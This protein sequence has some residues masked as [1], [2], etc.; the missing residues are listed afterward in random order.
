MDEELYATDITA[1]V[2]GLIMNETTRPGLIF[3]RIAACMAEIEAVG[4]DHR[5]PQQG[6]QFRSIDDFY[7]HCHPVLAKHRVFIS[8]TILD[9]KREE[10]TT[11]SGS[12]MMTTLTHVRYRVWTEDGSY[13]EADAIGEGADS[14]DKSANKSASMA[15]K[16]LLQQVFC[17]RVAGTKLDTEYDSPEYATPAPKPVPPAPKPVPPAPAPQA[18]DKTRFWAISKL[19]E[20]WSN[21]ELDR[22]FTET[23]GLPIAEW[24]LATVPTS[25]SDMNAYKNRVKFFFG[26]STGTD[27]P[28]WYWD[29]VIPIPR[30]GMKRNEYLQSPDT[31]RSLYD[32]LKAGDQDAGHRLWGLANEWQPAPYTNPTTGKTYPVR[33]EDIRSREA[34]DAFAAAHGD[35]Q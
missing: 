12:I 10:R 4:K 8:P 18:T 1:K 35:K 22:Y 9:V 19:Q 20:E 3:S 33:S 24:P 16:Y 13:I 26:T 2:Q 23:Y 31:I 6:Y 7:D 5:N 17:V 28:D 15:M 25:V 30:R 34:L 14:G 27:D 32:S 21:E 11:K 29:V